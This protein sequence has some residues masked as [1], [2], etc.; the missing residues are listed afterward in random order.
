MV[1]LTAKERGVRNY[2]TQ[3][4]NRAKTRETKRARYKELQ[5]FERK[6]V[7]EGKNG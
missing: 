6:M 5:D 1:S 4:Y 3:A 2:L 7:L